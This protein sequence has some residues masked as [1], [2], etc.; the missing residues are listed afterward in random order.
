MTYIPVIF[1]FL[2]ILF[3]VCDCVWAEKRA[4]LED[5]KITL[6]DVGKKL[7]KVYT[8]R[9]RLLKF[10]LMPLLLAFYLTSC[11]CGWPSLLAPLAG[12]FP[13]TISWLIVLAL[14]CGW[15]GDTLLEVSPKLFPAGLGSF[16]LGHVFYITAFARPFFSAEKPRLLPFFLCLIVCLLYIAFMV[17]EL[18]RI[19]ATKPLRIPLGLYLLALVLLIL[20]VSLRFSYASL[21]SACTGILGAALFITSDTILSFRM[22]KGLDERGIMSTYT[23][24]QLLLVLSFLFV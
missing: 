1:F 23:A 20:S 19:E 6:D 8:R 16:L 9:F 2:Y 10:C 18:F 13:K 22:F 21:L 3:S 24:A 5:G 15:A 4:H 17:R 7:A 14:V 11:L 12:G